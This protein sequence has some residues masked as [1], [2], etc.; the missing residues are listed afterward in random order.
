MLVVAAPLP[1][2][3]DEH[4]LEDH[5]TLSSETD[6][7]PGLWSVAPERANEATPSDEQRRTIEQLQAIGYVAGS[8]EP[9]GNGITL[10][11]PARAWPG[12]NLYTSGHEPVA[13][14]MDMEGRELHRWKFEYR[15]AFPD[16]IWVDHPNTAWWRRAYLY[17]NGDLLAIVEGFALLKLDKN[18]ELLWASPVSAHHDLDIRPNGDIYV[19]TR[20][21]SIIPRVNPEDP[22]LEDFIT[23]LRPDGTEKQKV[24]LLEAFES[25]K[26]VNLYRSQNRN[27]GDLFHTN[28][29]EVLDDRLSKRMPAFRAE[30]ILISMNNLSVI[31]VVDLDQQRVEWAV[32]GGSRGQHDPKI[33]DDGHLLLFDNRSTPG[34]SK[35][36][37]FDLSKGRTVWQYRGTK[38]HPFFSKHLGTAQRLPNGNTLITESESGRAF[39]VSHDKR[40]VWEFF[41]PHRAGENDRY[42]ATIFEL[43]RLPLDFPLDWLPKHTGG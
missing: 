37:E 19:L 26:F 1:L 3:A 31:A 11:D 8:S 30:R 23:I 9:R 32:K 13:I 39:E 42:I 25:S 24:S 21:A 36:L 35:V 2:H 15:D 4:T 17:P 27:H 22:V 34:V 10:N 16:S 29:L 41:N 12:I 28:S 40:I 5:T 33:L 43:L 14:L 18:S 20:E 6:A 7:G 38:Q